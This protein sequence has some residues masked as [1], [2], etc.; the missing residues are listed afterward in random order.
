MYIRP[1]RRLRPA[2]LLVVGGHLGPA[3]SALRG[4]ARHAGGAVARKRRALNQLAVVAVDVAGAG[5]AAVAGDARRKDVVAQGVAD[6]ARRGA[7]RAGEAAVGGDAPGGNLP[8][9]VK[10]APLKGREHGGF[11]SG[12]GEGGRSCERRGG[13]AL[14]VGWCVHGDACRHD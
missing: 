9:E 14:R 8:Q 11:F 1:R 12:Q 3:G 13:G 2:L 6:G 10:D 7:Q 4:L 5:D